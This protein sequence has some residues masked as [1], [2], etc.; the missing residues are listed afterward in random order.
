MRLIQRGLWWRKTI[1]HNLHCCIALIEHSC[2]APIEHCCIARKEH[3]EVHGIC[4]HKYLSSFLVSWTQSHNSTPWWTLYYVYYSV[5][6]VLTGH[7]MQQISFAAFY[8]PS[9]SLVPALAVLL[10]VKITCQKNK[11]GPFLFE[12]MRV[13]I[14]CQVF[15]IL[16]KKNVSFCW[17]LIIFN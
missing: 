12:R 13:I 14:V 3:R 11:S 16:S 7:H 1:F 8:L 6:Q 9:M 17:I 2:I 4:H 10:Q 15:W 5:W